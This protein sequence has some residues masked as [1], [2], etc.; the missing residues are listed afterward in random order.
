MAT[1][2]IKSS[3]LFKLETYQYELPEQLIAQYPAEP[4]DS[5]RLLVLDRSNGSKTDR[6]FRDITAYLHPGD[7]L[8]LNDTR[9]IPARLFAHKS[10]GAKIEILLLKKEG[11]NW[12]A[13]V[14]PARRCRPGDILYFAGSDVQL[15]ILEELP[16]A[17][18]R[19]LKF[20]N[21]GNEEEFL[22]NTGHV[23]LP[24]Y[25]NRS[26]EKFD[27]NRY[28]TVYAKNSGSAAA[29]TA[30][31]HFTPE[32]LQKI[33]NH[34]VNIVFILLHVGLGTFRP[35]TAEDIR[36]HQMHSE[37]YQLSRE[38]AAILNLTKE[39]GH[40]IIAVG[41]T[42]V[43]TLET[44]YNQESGFCEASGYTN[45]FIYPGYQFQAVNKLI[46][47]FHLPGSTLIMLIAAFAGIDNTLS[48][49]KYAV[50]NNYRFFSYGDAMLII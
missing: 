35:V 23:P 2:N 9:V 25:I 27:C 16:L 49:Y 1:H 44:V 26:D 48:A 17:G 19:L 34:G 11:L 4:R 21:C 8:V 46:S 6:V 39:K 20:I 50:E 47:N 5:S 13:L 33:K 15:E 37:Y 18:G 3:D 22:N 29:P 43:R 24:P 32:L 30:G 28:Q 31:L 38:T 36:D 10:S 12:E 40:N 45:K 42:V 14:K 41:T 7:T